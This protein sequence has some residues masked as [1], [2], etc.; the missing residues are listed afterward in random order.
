M[1]D[2]GDALSEILIRVTA[3]PDNGKAN[4]AVCS[5]VALS[6]GIAKSRVSVKRGT[7][8]RRKILALECD[9]DV[10]REWIESLPQV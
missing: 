6:V 1:S 7:T 4:K 3:P 8:S 2:A 5:L 9:D 10:L